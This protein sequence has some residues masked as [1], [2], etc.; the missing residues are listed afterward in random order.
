MAQNSLPS[1]PRCGS[2]CRAAYGQWY[3]D[4]CKA[5][6]FDTSSKSSTSESFNQALEDLGKGI[7]KGISSIERELKKSTSTPSSDSAAQPAC[8]TC[9]NGL[10]WV[11][12][13][14]RWYCRRCQKY[15]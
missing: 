2:P 1:C 12:Q 10:E 6:P 14:H 13:Y 3:C 11:A 9:G 15:A 7:S 5:Y 4:Q 8:L